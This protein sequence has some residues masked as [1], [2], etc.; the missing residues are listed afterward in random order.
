VAMD[1]C[2]CGCASRFQIGQCRSREQSFA[3][4]RGGPTSRPF[5]QPD[6]SYYPEVRISVYDLLVD[7]PDAESVNA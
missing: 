2:L 6:L 7:A 5:L 4:L 1:C 3:A